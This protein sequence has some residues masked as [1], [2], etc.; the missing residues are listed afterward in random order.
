MG[1]INLN[2]DDWVSEY[3]R[4]DLLKLARTLRQKGVKQRDQDMTAINFTSAYLLWDLIEEENPGDSLLKHLRKVIRKIKKPHH[5]NYIVR[6]IAQFL[7]EIK[8]EDLPLFI[9]RK[10]FVVKSIIKWRLSIGK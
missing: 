7:Y 6:A 2:P 10:A 5:G 8:Y 9:D 3:T 4:E 1:S